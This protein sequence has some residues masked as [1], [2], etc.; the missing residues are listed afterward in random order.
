MIV[1]GARGIS[2]IREIILGSVSDGVVHN[3][4]CPVLVVK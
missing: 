2:K 3:A 4:P 1:I